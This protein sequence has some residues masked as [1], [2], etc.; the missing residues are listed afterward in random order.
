VGYGSKYGFGFW[1]GWGVIFFGL[2]G[3]LFWV[4]FCGIRKE[5]TS[6]GFV[7]RSIMTLGVWIWGFSYIL[8]VIT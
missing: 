2:I 3:Y 6:A 4:S 8:G 1:V 7:R 5:G